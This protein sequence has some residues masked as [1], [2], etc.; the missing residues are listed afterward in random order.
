LLRYLVRL[1]WFGLALWNFPRHSFLPCVLCL[2]GFYLPNSA[3]DTVR[4]HRQRCLNENWRDPEAHIMPRSSF[5]GRPGPMFSTLSPAHESLPHRA[6]P[7]KSS[8]VSEQGEAR[9]KGRQAPSSRPSPNR[10]PQH[11]GGRGPSDLLSPAA[12]PRRK[13]GI[14]HVLSPCF[15][16][17]L[18]AC[19]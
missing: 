7:S 18:L 1:V 12:A 10:P 13:V 11:Q 8:R 19:L 9:K 15:Y 6:S 16:R 3:T 17:F 5:T 4:V 14:I 2:L